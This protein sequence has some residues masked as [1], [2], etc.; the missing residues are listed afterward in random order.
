MQAQEY[1]YKPQGTIANTKVVLKNL[2]ADLIIEGTSGGEIIISTS[3]YQGL[4]EKAKGLKPLSATGPENTGIGLNIK[5]EG[6]E[7]IISSASREAND[8][9]YLIKLPKNIKVQIDMNSWQAGDLLVKGMNNEVEAKSQS[10]DIKFVDVT[11]PIIAHTLSSDIDVVF[12]SINQSTPTSISSTSGDID[13]TLPAG[14][15]GTFSMSSIS[16][17]VYTDMDFDF[18]TEKD[19]KRFGGGMSAS[20]TLGGGGVDVSLKSVSGDIFIRKAK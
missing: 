13:I 10:G 8:S 9:E 3:D 1:I 20:A 17:E 12:T 6:N 5:Q 15:K 4:P 16:G 14:A 2:Y 7:I 11:G 19:L 18:S